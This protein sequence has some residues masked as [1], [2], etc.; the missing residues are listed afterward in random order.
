[1]RIGETKLKF[2]E[3]TAGPVLIEAERIARR[4]KNLGKKI[5]RDYADRTIHVVVVMNGA[6]VFAADLVRTLR[7]QVIVDF[8]RVSS[9]DGLA[10]SGSVRNRS[11]VPAD[12]DNEHVLLVEDIVDSGRTATRL[13]AQLQECNPRSLR[14]VSLMSKPARREI[15]VTI[16]Y[17]GFEIPNEFVVGYGT[18]FYKAFRHLPDIRVLR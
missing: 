5:D 2:R 15:D 9:Y 13:L 10:S 17:L 14:L 11:P 4:V 3:T 16:D 8:I 12:L 6:W 18:D 1:M 7:A